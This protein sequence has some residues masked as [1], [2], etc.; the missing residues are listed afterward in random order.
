LSNFTLEGGR[1][2]EQCGKNISVQ[3]V[4]HLETEASKRESRSA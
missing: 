3:R 1:Q 4:L 2:S